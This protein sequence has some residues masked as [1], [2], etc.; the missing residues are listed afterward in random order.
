MCGQELDKNP[1]ETLSEI[2]IGLCRAPKK[3]LKLWYFLANFFPIFRD[4][5]IKVKI[6]KNGL[7]FGS[8]A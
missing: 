7:V 4:L 1:S 3:L 2:K 5:P 6:V 8:R